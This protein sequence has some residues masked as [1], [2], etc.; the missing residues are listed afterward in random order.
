MFDKLVLA[1]KPKPNS[2]TFYV[3]VFSL[4]IILLI[5]FVKLGFPSASG[6]FWIALDAFVHLAGLYAMY[7]ALEKFD[8]ERV[9]ATIG[10]TQPIF[11]FGL[12]WIFFGPQSIQGIDIL[13]FILLFAGSL[14][15]SIEKTSANTLNYLKITVLASILFS[16]DYIFAKTVFIN[17]TFLPGIIWIGI[18][19]FL[20]SLAFLF[21]K[22]SRRE[23]FAKKM[24]SN[25]KTQIF[26][27]GAQASGGAANFLQSFAISLA[28]VAFLA[29]VNALKGVQY[30]FLFALTL[31]ISFFYPKFLKEKLS[32]KLVF[33]KAISILSIAA[34]LAILVIS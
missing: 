11:I 16:F 26:F 1:G 34:G 28:P 8:V 21:S 24:V 3:G 10:A 14:F 2:Y 6:F 30:V 13:A 4:S 5:P 17:Q 18:F 33:Q 7:S 31:V 23:I 25:K 29:T 19:M 22:K 27:L 15:I 9:V 32:K 20:F 12:T